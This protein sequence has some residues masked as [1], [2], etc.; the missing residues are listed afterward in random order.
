MK[1]NKDLIKGFNKRFRGQ[2]Q[3]LQLMQSS[4]LHDS[5]RN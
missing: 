5:G 3:K 4:S 1:N 2:K